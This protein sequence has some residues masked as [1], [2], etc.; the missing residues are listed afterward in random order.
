MRRAVKVMISADGA[1]A[2][3]ILHGLTDCSGIAALQPFTGCYL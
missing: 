2:L 3:H 1:S